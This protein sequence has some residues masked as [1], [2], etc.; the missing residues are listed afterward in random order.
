MTKIKFDIPGQLNTKIIVYDILGKEV[1]VPLND[2]L[3][4]GEYEIDFDSV[5]LP[6]GTYF[7]TLII[8]GFSET[9]KY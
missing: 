4:P 9:K 7:Y 8:E 6:R 1:T 5:N 2:S 3:K